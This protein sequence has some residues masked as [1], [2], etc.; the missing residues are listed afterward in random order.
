LISVIEDGEEEK[1]HDHA[2]QLTEELAEMRLKP[3][4]KELPAKERNTFY[5]TEVWIII[6]PPQRQSDQLKNT[7]RQRTHQQRPS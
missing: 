5:Y 6:G 7:C 1:D 3:A 2:N 4:Q